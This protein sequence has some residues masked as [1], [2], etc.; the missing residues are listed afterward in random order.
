MDRPLE[1]FMRGLTTETTDVEN[2]R[3]EAFNSMIAAQQ[4]QLSGYIA[5]QAAQ[6]RPVD[7]TA[8]LRN[9]IAAL[10]HEN[11]SLKNEILELKSQ[12][13][14]W[15]Y[16]RISVDAELWERQQKIIKT[17]PICWFR[18]VRVEWKPYK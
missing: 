12:L 1:H 2:K 8:K 11:L 9:E 5:M 6:A 14:P 17:C 3:N 10:V 4:A 18:Y 13:N 15:E 16:N 7:T